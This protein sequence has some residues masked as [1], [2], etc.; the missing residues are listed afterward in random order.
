MSSL[1]DGMLSQDE[2]DAL[3]SDMGGEDAEAGGGI[4][5]TAS[6][7]GGSALATEAG[8]LTDLEKDALGEIGNISMGAAAT[9]LSTILNKKV[10]ITAPRVSTVPPDDFRREYTQPSVVVDIAYTEGFSGNNFLVLQ[11]KD[12]AMIADLMMGGDGS[13][14]PSELNDLYLSAVAESMNQMMGSAA[15]SLS[16]I[17]NQKIEVSPPKIQ[18]A[19]FSDE[20]VEMPFLEQYDILVKIVFKM[21][22][23][24]LIDSSMVQLIPLEFGKEMAKGLLGD[25]TSKYAYNVREEEGDLMEELFEKSQAPE[26]RVT[27]PIPEPAGVEAQA[28][29]EQPVMQEPQP[30]TAE[31]QPQMYQPQYPPYQQPQAPFPGYGPT[32]TQTGQ[33]IQ[34]VQFAPLGGGVT[35][36]EKSNISLLMDVPM[37][38]TV[39]LG[40][41]RLYI[42]EI[43]ELS[44]GSIIEL[45]KLAGEPVDLLV[46]GKL[47][48]KGE[49]VVIDE[50][51]GVRVTDIV[52][53]AER[54]GGL[55][56]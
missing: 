17:F 29:P 48:A 1:N 16:T 20:S 19:D 43:L 53:P 7:P 33:V 46:N 31:P 15:T 36:E 38:L 25:R 56:T 30:R 52:S 39:E 27:T 24:G 13:S 6:E 10:D 9:V 50:N 51:F 21:T 40:K 49:V 32:Y 42:R 4:G 54:L 47:I 44:S 34:P 45:D 5:G 14:L 18:I 8:V 55:Q 28:P 2:L 26:E 35:Q 22:I 23:E 12:A 37:E 41:T 3:L 11:T